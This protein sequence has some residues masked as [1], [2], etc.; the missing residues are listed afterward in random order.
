LD[1]ALPLL[2]GGAV[3]AAVTTGVLG[4]TVLLPRLKQL[5]ERVLQLEGV[6]QKLLAQVR[7]LS[8]RGLD[9]SAKLATALDKMCLSWHELPGH[10]GR[11]ACDAQP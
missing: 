9:L 2:I 11:A 7:T 3:A 4:T 1:P 6:R 5:P 10:V 8:R